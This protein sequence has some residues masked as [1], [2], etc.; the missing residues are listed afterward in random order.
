[1][2][3]P[4]ADSPGLR[5]GPRRL[6]EQPVL[7]ERPDDNRHPVQRDDLDERA[8]DDLELVPDVGH[9]G[10]ADGNHHGVLLSVEE[11]QL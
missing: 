10:P 4:S 11:H 6:L 2:V 5:P 8:L 1:M 3:D 7:V 9:A